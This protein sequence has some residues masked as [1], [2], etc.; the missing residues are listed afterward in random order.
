MTIFTKSALVLAMTASAGFA[1]AAGEI[2]IQTTFGGPSFTSDTDVVGAVAGAVGLSSLLAGSSTA[3]D[4]FNTAGD[5]IGPR[6]IVYSPNTAISQNSTITFELTDG[7]IQSG[8]NLPALYDGTVGNAV[9]GNLID[10]TT[11]GNGNYTELR[12]QVITSGLV[13]S[14]GY[15]IVYDDG[16]NF[17]DVTIVANAGLSVGS[18]VSIAATSAQDPSAIAINQ[19]TAPAENVVTVVTPLDV[20]LLDVT[21]T[22]D[23]EATPSRGLFVADDGATGGFD[24]DEAETSTS[25]SRASFDIETIAELS[26]DFSTAGY[27]MTLS[28]DNDDG[29]TSVDLDVGGGAA[30]GA[31]TSSLALTGGDYVLTGSSAAIL[32][33]V[34]PGITHNLDITTSGT[35]VLQTGAWELNVDVD[36]GTG[37]SAFTAVDA[38]ETHDWDINGAQVKIPYHAQNVSGFV[39]FFNAV[40]ESSNDAAIFADVIVENKSQPGTRTSLT[41]VELGDAAANGSTTV[42]Q[43]AIKDAINANAPG[44]MNNDDV[45]HVAMTLTVIAPQN[46]IQIAAFQKDAVGRTMVPV[47]VNTNNS[48]DGRDW[49]Q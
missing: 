30:L 48:N 18:S 24:D 33:A 1:H 44:T 47:F 17:E 20:T 14:S 5:L 7:A 25:I 34:S 6:S 13:A 10:F 21:S 36:A 40:N 4:L 31:G 35:D 23:V 16:S 19:G 37:F 39:F 11:D 15:S 3:V 38:A 2:D 9:V 32:T 43:Q 26:P 27:T 41:N 28:R 12:F 8:T 42:G 29:V 46:A 49:Q 45:Y 22:I